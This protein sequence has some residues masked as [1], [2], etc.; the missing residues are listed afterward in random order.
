MTCLTAGALAFAVAAA[1]AQTTPSTWPT[2]LFAPYAFIPYAD[3]AAP[4]LAETGQ[5]FY[6]LAFVLSDPSG[7]PAWDGQK[8]L[9]VKKGFFADIIRA[10]RAAGGDVIISFGG[11]SGQELA[12]TA[13][14]PEDLA[15]KYGS[16]VDHLQASWLDFDIEGKALRDEASNRRRNLALG[17]L[18]ASHP[19]VRITFTV[20]ALPN[21]MEDSTRS[22]L[23]EAL[24]LGVRM[25]SVNVMTMDYARE[26]AAG[27]TM[28]DLAIAAARASRR[29][30]LAMGL[31]VKLGITPMIGKN[32][33]PSVVFTLSDA[34][35]LAE[36]ARG[37]DWIRSVSFW[38]INRDQAVSN[39]STKSDGIPQAKWDFTR[40]LQFTQ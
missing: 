15:A 22:M 26:V 14:S 13:S 16:V 4:C 31:G 30:L 21:G 19:G 27:G 25:E 39:D 7:K 2:K 10:I 3:A 12:V 18:Q 1:N 37:A 24:R 6:T 8:R 28:S 33:V 11:E 23:A 5:K 36:F 32:D 29:Q 34:A 40:A 35:R 38:S 20:P 17:Q 9:R